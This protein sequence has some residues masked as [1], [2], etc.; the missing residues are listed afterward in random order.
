[1]RDEP[2]I[3]ND[4]IDALSAGRSGKGSADGHVK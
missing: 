2:G 1:M 3:V 4:L